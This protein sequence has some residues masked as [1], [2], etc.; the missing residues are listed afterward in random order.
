MMQTPNQTEPQFSRAEVS[1]FVEDGRL[2]S[3]AVATE[4]LEFKYSYYD[5]D[6]A[7]SV[8]LTRRFGDYHRRTVEAYVDPDV[9]QKVVAA[10]STGRGAGLDEVQAAWKYLFDVAD[11]MV[12][13][14]RDFAYIRI[15]S[16]Y[17]L[18]AVFGYQYKF[19]EQYNVFATVEWK[20][21]RR[22]CAAHE[23]DLVPREEVNLLKHYLENVLS[24]V[25]L[26]M[27]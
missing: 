24:L 7:A 18:T 11:I 13:N 20:E 2:R 8:H 12:S 25:R 22:T 23:S 5:Y 6:N 16:D 4:A 14:L 3:V 10:F 15:G 27:P 17:G 21:D 1:V 9:A 19:D 26:C